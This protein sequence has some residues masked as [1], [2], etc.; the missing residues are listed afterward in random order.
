M[1]DKVFDRI[2][3]KYLITKQ[4]KRQLMKLIKRNM[5]KDSYHESEVLN[6]YFD[7]DNYDLITQS[8]DW[9]DFKEKVRARSYAGYDR[10]FMEIKTKI[11]P[12]EQHGKHYEYEDIEENIGYKR[13][14]MITHE[15]FEELIKHRTT[16]ESLA[17]RSIETRNDL[18]IAREIDY[19]L[20]HFNLKPKIFITYDRESYKDDNGLRITFDEHLKYR[21]RNLSFVKGKRDKIYFKDD[22]NIIMEIK[23]NGAIPLWLV[24]KLSELKLYP[25]KYSKIGKIYERI[26]HV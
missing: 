6:I 25:Q 22:H 23:V 16:L 5:Q 13:R 3:K 15:D 4:D 21:N 19:L 26:N 20:D 1:E 9:V 10:V 7:N 2:E 12:A 8:I 18:Q 17:S 11:H 24:H 14:V